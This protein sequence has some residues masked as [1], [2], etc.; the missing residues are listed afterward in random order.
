MDLRIILVAIG[1]LIIIGL[2]VVD[3]IK[4]KKMQDSSYRRFSEDEEFELPSMSATQ[5]T[6]AHDELDGLRVDETEELQSAAEVDEAEELQSAAEVDEVVQVV[7]EDDSQQPV[8]VVLTD[9]VREPEAESDA[10]TTAA[11]ATH[12][13]PLN[14]HTATVQ[15]PAQSAS[16]P[17]P[18]LEPE[19]VDEVEVEEE[20]GMVLSL[21]VLAQKGEKFRGSQIKMALKE[22]GF[23]YGD[24]D[25]FHQMEGDEALVSIANVLEPGTFELDEISSLHTPGLVLFAQL[26]ASCSGDELFNRWYRTARKLKA[27]LGGKLT[28]MRQQPLHD[29]Y[30]NRLRAEAEGFIAMGTN[31]EQEKDE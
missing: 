29:D 19:Q 10:E 5:D 7:V 30:V 14:D 15:I 11:Q 2:I 27:A 17:E 26:P 16:R 21:L 4:R 13:Q 22:T 24:M 8:G 31:S 18:E 23:V 12:D 6:P 25:I 20:P 9:S 3:R 1:A 28:D